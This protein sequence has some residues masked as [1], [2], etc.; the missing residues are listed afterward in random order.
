MAIDADKRPIFGRYTLDGP[1]PSGS[2]QRQ[3]ADGLASLG[4][5]GTSCDAVKLYND[6]WTRVNAA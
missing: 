4:G 1:T 3:I 5:E 6:A 2:L